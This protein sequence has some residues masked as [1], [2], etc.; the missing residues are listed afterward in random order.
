MSLKA[1]KSQDGVEMTNPLTRTLLTPTDQ[2][3]LRELS[4]STKTSTQRAWGDIL[5]QNL[6]FFFEVQC[7]CYQINI[8][9]SFEQIGRG[10]AEILECLNHC[11]FSLHNRRAVRKIVGNK[12][13]D[14]TVSE[15]RNCGKFETVLVLRSQWIS[16]ENRG[17]LCGN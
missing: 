7:V 3:T 14:V 6:Y 4:P 12:T 16:E 9:W 17:V 10:I 13:Y 15:L 8:F 2:A 11:F 1:S 5:N